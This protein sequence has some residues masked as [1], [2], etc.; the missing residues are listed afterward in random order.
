MS[1]FKT[2]I[3]TS[4]VLGVAYGFAGRYVFDLPLDSCMLAGGLCS[5]SGMLPDLDSD[6]GIPA[7]ET[8]SFVSTLVPMLLIQ[9]I[10]ELHLSAEQLVLIGAFVYF[11]VRFGVG[12]LFRRFTLHRG[13]WHSVP[14]AV[15][16][17]I[18]GFLLCDCEIY[19]RFY[20]GWAVILGFMSHLILDELHSVD[21]N[22]RSIRV[23]KSFGT[24]IKF[25]GDKP[26]ANIV[27]YGCMLLLA[28]LVWF[29]PAFQR[30]LKSRGIEV[31]VI[32]RQPDQQKL[33]LPPLNLFRQR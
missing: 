26:F 7:R 31:P 5:I 24:A 29:D 18:V 6:S 17:G 30:E 25:F 10:G 16:A 19:I 21:M 9:R 1:D 32:A 4:T 15:I 13:M 8:L 3:T 11:L 20:K 14:A 28:S 33:T 2:H 27:T 23:K 22:G 12:S